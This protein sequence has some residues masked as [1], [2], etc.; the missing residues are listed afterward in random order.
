M[1]WHNVINSTCGLPC[2]LNLLCDFKDIE[3]S[4]A[5]RRR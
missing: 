3:M 5:E 2:T 4:Q 1:F